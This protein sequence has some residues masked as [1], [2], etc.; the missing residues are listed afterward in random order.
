MKAKLVAIA[1]VTSVVLAA[2]A[3][4]ATVI[5]GWD[6]SQYAVPNVL[7]ADGGATFSDTLDANYSSF[8]PTFGAGAESAAF[9]TMFI[10]G[11]NGSTDIDPTVDGS[12]WV[13][14]AGSLVSNLNTPKHSNGVPFDT[15]S[16][17][18][19]EGQPTF[20]FRSM[21]A[22]AAVDVVFG[23]DISTVP[24]FAAGF[25]ISFAGLADEGTAVVGVEFST[26]GV[27]YTSL[28][29]ANLTSNDTLFEFNAG[30]ISSLVVDE[31]FFRLSFS[32]PTTGVKGPAL[33][34][35]DNVT[36]TAGKSQITV[37]ALPA[38]GPILLAGLL[39]GV[40]RVFRPRRSARA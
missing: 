25:S 15:Q 32:D 39:L 35:I 23:V 13:P 20:D 22:E 30:V 21:T 34:V 36:V 4:Q 1:T 38:G 40:S 6:F 12:P 37:P 14:T 2:S 5:A 10:N 24:D 33:P 29:E 18:L 27:S 7:T 28:G 31:A 3:A 8:D 16:V 26:D 19:A 11:A 17:L 9:G